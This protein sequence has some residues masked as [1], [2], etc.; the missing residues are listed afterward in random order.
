MPTRMPLAASLATLLLT[1]AVRAAAPA[2]PLTLTPAP[3]DVAIANRGG[4]AAG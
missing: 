3:I 4:S 1:A 2:A